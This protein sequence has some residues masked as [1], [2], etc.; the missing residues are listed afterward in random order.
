MH[1]D[2][3]VTNDQAAEEVVTAAEQIEE[4]AQSEEVAE[5]TE[6]TPAAEQKHKNR[7]S[8]SEKAKA[9]A[10]EREAKANTTAE[11]TRNLDPL[12]LRGKKYRAVVVK[13]E[14]ARRYTPEEAM[15]LVK[16]VSTASFDAAVELHIVT[17]GEGV[18]GTI[19]LPHGN[20]KTRKVV[21]A[22]DEVLEEIAAGKLDFD[23][24]LAT[25]AQ[26]PKLAKFAKL[27]GPK[28]LMPSPK[29]GTVTEDIEGTMAQIN[30]GRVEYRAD[31]TGVIHLS[32][33]R[34]SFKNEQLLENYT[35][36]MQAL[37]SAKIQA[38]YLTPTMG[39]SVRLALSAK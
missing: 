24:L 13:V 23:V 8:T 38:A 1:M 17:K 31:K 16:E 18:R 37:T 30:S 36:L 20:G 25:P 11:L 35:T 10:A 15:Q 39:P 34:V 2:E 6:E 27:P 12:R 5:A 9:A 14:K 33:G 4:V 7:Q 3:V 28:G 19:Q 21:A 32:I 29:A 26:M 22:T